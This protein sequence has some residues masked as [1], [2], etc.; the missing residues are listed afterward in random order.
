MRLLSGILVS[1]Y[2]GDMMKRHDKILGHLNRL[3]DQALDLTNKKDARHVAKIQKW[4]ARV[5]E[6]NDRD[7]APCDDTDDDANDFFVFDKED[8]CK[9]NSQIMSAIRS[10]ARRFACNGRGNVPR[11]IARRSNRLKQN[12]ERRK[13][14]VSTAQETTAAPQ[15]AE[16]TEPPTEPGRVCPII[17]HKTEEL[18]TYDEAIAYCYEQGMELSS[19]PDNWMNPLC[20]HHMVEIITSDVVDPRAEQHAWINND[21]GECSVVNYTKEYFIYGTTNV[22]YSPFYFPDACESKFK[23]ICS[24]GE[25]ETTTRIPTTP[26]Y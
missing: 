11:Q 7:G 10:F 19:V 6:S 23:A 17:Y 18:L 20:W 15:T 12:F 1:A 16:S 22:V 5:V 26:D 3:A 25:F 8:S 13:C 2:A 4:A 21:N 14:G 9:L 24:M